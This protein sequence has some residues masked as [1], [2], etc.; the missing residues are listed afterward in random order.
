MVERGLLAGVLDAPEDDAPRLVYADWLEE[1]GGES[2]RAR[3]EFIRLQV[4]RAGLEPGAPEVEAI[5]RR[6]D[7][8]LRRYWR[9]WD[10]EL[11]SLV[12]PSSEYRRGFIE[13]IIPYATFE[14]DV[15]PAL[16]DFLAMA[17]R[18]WDLAPI[19]KL[20]LL[21]TGE[22]LRRA[23]MCDRLANLDELHIGADL[24]EGE[25]IRALAA[26]P[27]LRQLTSLSFAAREDA[28]VAVPAL[29][30]IPRPR[31]RVLHLHCDDPRA[32][33][34][35][36]VR[37][38]VV[39]QLTELELSGERGVVQAGR[40]LAECPALGG[41]TE[42]S[43]GLGDEGS[44]VF[45][46]SRHLHSL[47]TLRLG[48][49][50]LGAETATA[51]AE[52][53]WFDSVRTLDLYYNELGAEGCEALAGAR[54]ANLTTLNLGC[55]GLDA[56]ALEALAAGMRWPRL[57][58]LVLCHNDLGNE[59]INVLAGAALLAPLTRLNLSSNRIGP[60]GAQA[61]A[62]SPHLGQLRSLHLHSNR[63]GTGGVTALARS[64]AFPG[65]VDL[66]VGNNNIGDQGVRALVSSLLLQR[67]RRLGL[68]GNHFGATAL[69][70]LLEV[71]AATGLESLDLQ[72]CGLGDEGARTLAD[73]APLASLFFLDIGYNDITDEGAR[74]LLRCP[75]LAGVAHVKW[76]GNQIE[77]EEV[78]AALRERF[79]E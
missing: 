9:S 26:V 44:A 42:L 45:F 36:L 39:G 27:W 4:R 55:N 59:A 40:T 79:P 53:P 19:R 68:G 51:L 78:L 57:S 24:D 66:D 77:D 43:L 14:Q 60:A 21:E 28:A 54:P 75:W 46:R 20:S 62:G 41:L 56:R 67:L 8:L 22:A 63:I 12:S 73:A 2:D 50:N 15:T 30:E 10:V 76:G 69:A 71:L 49:A 32:A 38:P 64:S 35:A 16:R 3:A 33:V 70:A 29:F 23:L 7:E 13:A 6:E 17:P 34:A 48:H 1:H 31:L 58:D 5:Q 65:L 37:S 72:G 47:R 74:H 52:A 11:R 18:F 25:D 61:L